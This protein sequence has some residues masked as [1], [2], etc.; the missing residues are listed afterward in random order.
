MS[1]TERKLTLSWKRFWTT[2]IVWTVV[3][4]AA[5]RIIAGFL[6]GGLNRFFGLD[7]EAVVLCV[8]HSRSGLAID[9]TLLSKRLNVPVAK[10]TMDGASVFEREGMTRFALERLPNVKLVLYD[11]DSWTFTGGGLAAN[12]YRLML[13]FLDDPVVDNY[14][15]HHGPGP[16]TLQMYRLLHTT[17][18]DEAALNRALRGWLNLRANLKLGQVNPA[19]MQD[20]I[21][22]ARARRIETSPV[23]K[24]TFERTLGMILETKIPILLWYPPTIDLLDNIATDDREAIRVILRN[25]AD[26]HPQIHY[27]QYLEGFSNRHEWFYDAIHVNDE[28][29]R[30]ITEALAADILEL[31]LLD[32][33]RYGQNER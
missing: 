22:G 4:L 9:E 6:L 25:V 2:A 5:D 29:R 14:M 3:L 21:S 7:G 10:Y 18:Y 23:A 24:E 12:A 1:N 8:G 26:R 16:W 33:G 31:G 32:G 11:V 30:Q 28:G 17:R 27:R 13:P 15:R 19:L 20:Q